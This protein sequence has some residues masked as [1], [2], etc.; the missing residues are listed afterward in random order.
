MS[1]TGHRR[2]TSLVFFSMV[3]GRKNLHAQVMAEPPGRRRDVADGVIPAA[4]EVELMGIHPH[5]GR[6]RLARAPSPPAPTSGCGGSWW[7]GATLTSRCRSMRESAPSPVSRFVPPKEQ[8]PRKLSGTRDRTWLGVSGEQ[9]PQ[10]FTDGVSPASRPTV[11]LS[12]SVQRG[13]TRPTAP[14][15]RRNRR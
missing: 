3:D 14:P 13:R 1:S 5:A 2:P 9:R 6:R 10:A 8:P 15:P 12:G 4:T 7:R 11:K